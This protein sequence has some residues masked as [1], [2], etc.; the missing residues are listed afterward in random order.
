LIKVVAV[1]MGDMGGSEFVLHVPDEYDYRYSTSTK[2]IMIL[3]ALTIGYYESTKS[4]LKFFFKV[5]FF[6]N[7]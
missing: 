2:R 1:T 3:I 7:L 5:N 6:C 4:K